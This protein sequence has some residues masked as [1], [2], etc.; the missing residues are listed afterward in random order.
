M[1]FIGTT[2]VLFSPF[3]G[4]KKLLP[5]FIG[6]KRLHSPFIG[7][8]IYSLCLSGGSYSRRLSV[9]E[10]TVAVYLGKELLPPFIGRGIN[11]CPLSGKKAL[12]L[13]VGV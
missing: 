1:P 12:P 9:A 2:K 5:P 11:F 7:V 4:A 6:R 8:N 10:K 3:I 13:F